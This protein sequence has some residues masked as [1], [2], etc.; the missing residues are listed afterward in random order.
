M[1][2]LNLNLL[3]S[4]CNMGLLLYQGIFLLW[5]GKRQSS[6]AVVAGISLIV[7][8]AFFV[9]H[10][11]G[12]AELAGQ[13]RPAMLAL[14]NLAL[15][16]SIAIAYLFL[17]N[18]MLS[19]RPS[20]T[21]DL[22]G[23]GTVTAR[24]EISAPA[25]VILACVP[26]LI[27]IYLDIFSGG[28][29]A[30]TGL[31]TGS[32]NAS[33]FWLGM[34]SGTPVALACLFL[35]RR[36]ASSG[37]KGRSLLRG[38]A[39]SLLLLLLILIGGFL[40]RMHG[41]GADLAGILILDLLSQACILSGIVFSSQA[42]VL[43]E[44]FSGNMPRLGMHRYYWKN[45]RTIVVLSLF[46]VTLSALVNPSPWD[47]GFWFL[48]PVMFLSIQSGYL[49]YRLMRDRER[50]L[51]RMQP[52]DSGGLL[53]LFAEGEQDIHERASALL[54]RICQEFG[55][56]EARI[57]P[58]G[59]FASLLGAKTISSATAISSA[60][61]PKA[62]ATPEAT[63][64]A[65]GER[66]AVA[67][68]ELATQGPGKAK[69]P[70]YGQKQQSEPEIVS[71]FS[72]L[73]GE[74]QQGEMEVLGQ[75]LTREEREFIRVAGERLLDSMAILRFSSILMDL[76]KQYMHSRK[77]GETMARR[78]L[79]D[80]VLPDIHGLILEKLSR[81][82]Q[83]SVEKEVET[84]KALHHRVAGLLQDMPGYDNSL[85]SGGLLA[86]LQRIGN[87]YGLQID[88]QAPEPSLSDSEREMVFYALREVLRNATRYANGSVQIL[89]QSSTNR[90]D[91]LIVQ[92]GDVIA[93]GMARA[94]AMELEEQS[95]A[96]QGLSIHSA[97]LLL[98]GGGLEVL[99]G[100][101]D[102]R[103]RIFMK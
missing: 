47:S 48:L 70:G 83:L 2:L 13:N 63:S 39:F 23:S 74:G 72:L 98:S 62:S 65:S 90:M 55:L 77:L 17:I 22:A 60:N 87:S 66:P 75:R 58:L 16:F 44:V 10:A 11:I 51:A 88:L 68:S 36:R 38:A 35:I 53:R 78:V 34:A 84:L 64:T 3:L 26:A 81:N 28:E 32:L 103:L 33:V 85:G 76:Q 50:M 12:L 57:R 4:L 46:V 59:S 100:Q 54:L 61:G 27:F 20:A 6:R 96:G 93:P 56:R 8:A 101:K 89:P 67:D 52:F 31:L 99:S 14:V 37:L 29:T 91:W 69:S 71:H 95:G 40:L 42:S 43:Y 102:F 5:S 80:E 21:P 49:E 30:L 97:L 92:D 1:V 45:V 73:G 24:P 86:A 25:A 94:G 19:E 15:Y 7:A 79:H 9:I 41:V 18:V 82:A